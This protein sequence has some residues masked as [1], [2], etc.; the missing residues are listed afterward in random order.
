MKTDW[1]KVY[2][3]LDKDVS[4]FARVMCDIVTG[5]EELPAFHTD[6]YKVIRDETR[7]VIAAPRGFAKSSIISKIYPLWC[8]LFMKKKEICIISASEGLAVEHIR[9]IKGEIEG[10]KTINGLWGN[11]ISDKWTENHLII[12][13]KNGWE[14]VIRARGAGGQIR[15]FRPDALI[16]DDI[17]TDDSVESEEQRK[18]LKDW[19]F[20]ACINT[21]LPGGQFVVIGTV[22]HH[23]SVLNDLLSSPNGWVKRRYK[24]YFDGIEEEGHELWKDKRP[25]A[26]L[27]ERKKEIGSHRFYAEFMNNPISDETAPI[28]EKHIR[29]WETLPAQLSIVITLDPAYSDDEAS[30][31]KTV[32]AVGSD[33]KGNR[34]LIDYIR[35]HDS[36]G[37]FI[38]QA[39]NLYLRYKDITTAFGVPDGGVEKQTFKT[40]SDKAFERRL[41]IPIVPLKN[42]VMT[43]SGITVRKKRSRIVAALQPIFERGQYYIHANHIEARDELL[44]IGSSRWDDIV[45]ALAYAETIITPIYYSSKSYSKDTAP[46][47]AG[48]SSGYGIEY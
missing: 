32:V 26:W 25:H 44:T 41:S 23:L 47:M 11:L 27:Q 48:A 13:H 35:T 37:S 39:F 29:Y 33:E 8:A 36:F 16:V 20:R 28:Q 31:Y 3:V 4:K 46:S 38:D 24:A 22:I 21:L 43:A 10:N 5:T 34:Y 30:D 6:I 1:K 9:W 12:K 14:T 15:G 17:E 40:I 18:K 2:E 42:Q 7:V 45:D 19:L